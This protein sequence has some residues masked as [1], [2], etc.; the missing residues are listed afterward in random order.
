MENR[1]IAPVQQPSLM[2]NNFKQ[3]QNCEYR[4]NKKE[5]APT[6]AQDSLSYGEIHELAINNLSDKPPDVNKI[7]ADG[8]ADYG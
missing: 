1:R 6:K 5:S 2:L 3:K 7:S 4:P 8:G